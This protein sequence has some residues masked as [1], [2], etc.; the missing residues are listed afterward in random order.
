MTT[1]IRK[2][3]EKPEFHIML[4]DAYCNCLDMTPDGKS[5]ELS[6]NGLE[7]I[8]EYLFYNVFD[9]EV[10]ESIKE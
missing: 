4:G 10:V 8:I 7:R 6:F 1:E 3:L 9:V 2:V 5:F